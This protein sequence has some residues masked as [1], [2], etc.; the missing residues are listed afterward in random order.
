MSFDFLKLKG[1]LSIRIGRGYLSIYEACNIKVDD[2][3]KVNTQKNEGFLIYFNDTYLCRTDIVVDANDKCFLKFFLNKEKKHIPIIEKTNL[4][5]TIEF[6]LQCYSNRI[7]L[8]DLQKV[9]KH[10]FLE[11]INDNINDNIKLVV[12]GNTIAEGKIVT[13]N[14]NFGIK[15]INTFVEANKNIP[16]K[17]SGYIIDKKN[18]KFVIEDYDFKY[19]KKLSNNDFQKVEHIHE[20]LIKNLNYLLE[21]NNFIKLKMNYESF[22]KIKPLIDKYDSFLILEEI[23]NPMKKISKKLKKEIEHA[24]D[25][26]IINKNKN[27]SIVNKNTNQ[28][29]TEIIPIV[30][31]GIRDIC[32]LSKLN[33]ESGINQFIIEPLNDA[34][35]EFS[36]TKFR[37]VS[38]NKHKEVFNSL[39]NFPYRIISVEIDENML[40]M[41]PFIYPF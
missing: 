8:E 39:D 19:P 7:S 22:N 13:I 18:S 33:N 28:N 41:Y 20:K 24:D 29:K 16:F 35:K 36:Y 21:D 2:I 30:I 38:A 32:I 3:I 40:I 12:M 4:I 14:D 6:N 37:F 11:I 17:S 26:K 27:V 31:I 23:I 10:D 9:K 34:W 25:L 15:I 5:D 1:N